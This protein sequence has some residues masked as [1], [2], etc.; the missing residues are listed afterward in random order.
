[1][2]CA[3]GSLVQKTVVFF[4]ILSKKLIFSKK[5]VETTYFAKALL[6]RPLYSGPHKPNKRR[7]TRE[8]AQEQRGEEQMRAYY[9]KVLRHMLSTTVLTGFLSGGN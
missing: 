6:R 7:P 4:L 3:L 2:G 5:Y 8:A 1:L 9:V